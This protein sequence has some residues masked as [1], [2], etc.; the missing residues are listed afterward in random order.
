MDELLSSGA[1]ISSAAVPEIY[2]G[3]VDGANSSGVE[4]TL[5]GQSSALSKR[6][7]M[8][9][10]GRT[11]TEGERVLILKMSGTYVVLGAIASAA[12]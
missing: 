2:L 10:T 6:Y 11:L 3:T 12:S 7:K 1:G 4:I 5:D 8:L 9:L